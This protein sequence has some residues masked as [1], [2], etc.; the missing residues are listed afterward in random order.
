M[1][2]QYYPLKSQCPARECDNKQIYEWQLVDCSHQTKINSKALL[3]CSECSSMQPTPIINHL[4]N[5]GEHHD[6]EYRG[7]DA[8]GML[9]AL[10]IMKTSQ[11]DIKNIVW[12]DRLTKSFM[13][14]I[15]K[16]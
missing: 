6:N 4:F 8:L 15:A 13:E 9:Q 11:K 5:C 12:L 16:L 3:K 14:E 1:C 10:T 2:D 7:P